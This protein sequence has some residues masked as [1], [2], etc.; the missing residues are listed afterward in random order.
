MTRTRS[1]TLGEL[2]GV[3]APIALVTLVLATSF[4]W[5]AAPFEDAAMIMRYADHLA[6]GHGIRWNLGDPPVDGATDFLFMVA[7]AAIARLGAA[8][9]VATRVLV[10]AAHLAAVALVYL[11]TRRSGFGTGPAALAASFLAVGP[12]L[13]YAEA[14]FGT[15]FFAFWA[16][17]AWFFAIEFRERGTT[18]AGWACALASL[19]LGLTRPDGVLLAGL[20]FLGVAVTVDRQAAARLLLAFALVFGTLGLGY[21]AWRWSYFG[22]PLPNPY[23]KKGGFHLWTG[24]LISSIRAVAR[25]LLP[26]LPIYALAIRDARATREALFSALP[27]VG[28]T[29]VWILLS[30]EMN[31][32]G[33]FQYA[34]VPIAAMSAPALIESVRAAWQVPPYRALELRARVGVAGLA[35]AGGVVLPLLLFRPALP[36][37]QD[38]RA[39][40]GRALAPYADEGYTLATTEAGLLPLMSGWRAIDTWGLNDAEIAHSDEGI[41][42][43]YLDANRPA[44]VLVHAAWS[45]VFDDPRVGAWMG[46]KWDL[47]TD[48]LRSWCE[49]NGYT[50]AAAWGASHAD[51]FAWWVDPACPDHDAFVA[52]VRDASFDTIGGAGPFVDFARVRGTLHLPRDTD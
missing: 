45:P 9:E 35:L 41:T 36:A 32:L 13:A 3:A 27:I 19:G 42:D 38:A 37:G 43:A 40:I 28:F 25:F 34:V 50:L 20:I 12:G 24:S 26:L 51:T 14:Y 39:V 11:R 15:P 47:M 31:F 48:R 30:D 8:V 22:H 29:G 6:S 10:L 1:A 4:E 52:L 7:V 2:A 33:R 18:A 17:L 49:R 16:A 21:F 23:Y 46:P 5:A 44:I